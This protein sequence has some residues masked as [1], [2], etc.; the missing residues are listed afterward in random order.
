MIIPKI[1]KFGKLEIWSHIFETS[2]EFLD[3]LT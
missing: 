2:L 1:R 3:H